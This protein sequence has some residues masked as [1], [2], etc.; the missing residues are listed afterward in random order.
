VPWLTARGY[1]AFLLKY[2]ARGMP[3]SQADYGE[4]VKLNS[5]ID[6]RKGRKALRA[7]S[8]IVPDE[9]IHEVCEAAADDGRGIAIVRER[10]KEWDIDRATGY[11]PALHSTSAPPHLSTPRSCGGA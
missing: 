2:H 11:W 6:M 10:A 5:Q 4:M 7:R 9:S 3:A 1:T 8:D